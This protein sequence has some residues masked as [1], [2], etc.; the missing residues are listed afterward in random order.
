MQWHKMLTSFFPQ[1][2]FV[3]YYFRFF[4]L[5]TI[6]PQNIII[7]KI[8]IP[9]VLSAYLPFCFSFLPVSSSPIWDYFYCVWRILHCISFSASLLVRNSISSWLNLLKY[10]TERFSS[11]FHF[12]NVFLLIGTYFLW[13]LWEYHSIISS[14]HS[15]PYIPG[16]LSLLLSPFSLTDAP[17][18][19]NY[20]FSPSALRIF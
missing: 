19:V 9:L 16:Q 4:I 20:L 6:K 11:S 14:Y 3:S 13:A 1:P 7:H 15:I 10:L 17:L 5:H 8:T 2:Q 12:Q 18:K